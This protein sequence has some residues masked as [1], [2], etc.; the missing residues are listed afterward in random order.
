MFRDTELSPLQRSN[1][2]NSENERSMRQ[3]AIEEKVNKLVTV[4]QLLQCFGE[5]FF[6]TEWGQNI[7]GFKVMTL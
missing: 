3:K 4:L 7:P 2:G 1:T 6:L 5:S